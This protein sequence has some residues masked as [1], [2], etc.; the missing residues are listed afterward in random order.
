KVAV[1]HRC[2]VFPIRDVNSSPA[3]TFSKT[4]HC[5]CPHA[6]LGSCDAARQGV[7][8]LLPLAATP[9][10]TSAKAITADKVRIGS[11]RKGRAS[12]AILT[13]I[14]EPWGKVRSLDSKSFVFPYRRRKGQRGSSA[15]PAH[16]E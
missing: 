15:P 10:P 11:H 5:R 9:T 12:D 7:L 1:V 13:A 2:G 14:Q 3:R 8:G 4:G 6:E 16:H